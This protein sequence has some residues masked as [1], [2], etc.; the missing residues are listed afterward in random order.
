[1]ATP[2]SGMPALPRPSRSIRSPRARPNRYRNRR[3]DPVTTARRS[4]PGGRAGTRRAG[5]PAPPGS[6]RR[7]PAR[8][9]AG[10]RPRC[11]ARPARRPSRA[12]ARVRRHFREQL[13][14]AVSRTEDADVRERLP[15]QRGQDLHVDRVIVGDQHDRRFR[16]RRQPGGRVIRRADE[17]DV[18]RRESLAHPGRRAHPDDG[19]VPSNGLRDLHERRGVIAG[20]EDHQRLR[21]ADRFEEDVGTRFIIGPFEAT[22]G[23]GIRRG[24]RGKFGFDHRDKARFVRFR[25]RRRLRIRFGN[26]SS[27]S[28]ARPSPRPEHGRESHGLSFAEHSGNHRHRPGSFRRQRLNEH[29][30]Y[31]AAARRRD[32]RRVG[33][34]RRVVPRRTGVP[35]AMTPRP[36]RA[37]SRSRHPPLTPPHVRPSSAMSMRAPGRRYDDP[38]TAT[39]VASAAGLPSAHSCS[40]GARIWASSCMR[41]PEHPIVARRDPVLPRIIRVTAKQRFCSS[42]PT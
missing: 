34:F 15:R 37:T 23:G 26:V 31:P 24:P 12:A 14:G 27:R 20:A 42:K 11:P 35:L 41:L 5:P 36:R 30:D 39:T 13:L 7:S 16:L 17:Q 40:K 33:I 19:H 29:V 9:P 22:H 38:A 28:H 4:A 3:Q 25:S 8:S 6:P 1:M 18:G 10:C 32:V 2:A 21:R